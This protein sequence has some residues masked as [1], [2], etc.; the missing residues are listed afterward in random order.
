LARDS[1]RRRETLRK[2]ASARRAGTARVTTRRASSPSIRGGASGLRRAFDLLLLAL[3]APLAASG[4]PPLADVHVHYKWSQ[5]EIT[6]PA[7]AIRT[8]QDND[9][10]LAVV[11]GTPAEYALEL[12]RLAPQLIIPIWSPYRSPGD[13]SS[14][15]YD[16][17]LLQRARAALATGSYAGIGELHLIGGFIPDWRTPV[18]SGL[19]ELAGEY[20]FPLLV[21][22]EL[23]ETSYLLELCRAHPGLRI[24][25]AHAGAILDAAQV[26]EVMSACPDVW[27]ELSARDP[28]RFV[29][30]PIVDPAGI[31]LPEWRSLIETYPG[32]F[33]VGSDPV[34]PVEQLD[35]WDQAD[36]GWQHYRR[37]VEFHR[38]WLGQ[39]APSLAEKLRLR[40]ARALF[41]V[42]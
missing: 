9:V 17:G 30:N 5:R 21:H 22:T 24:L 31:L 39:L 40:N 38:G 23:S 6:P 19:I 18:I 8:L 15:P 28:W 33:M 1:S 3:I 41:A 42:H 4:A 29:K 34:W 10:A 32:R 35:S 13:W 2:K 12:Q 25:W 36:T 14:W 7:D 11:I 27:S 26:G 37:F 16:K 20:E